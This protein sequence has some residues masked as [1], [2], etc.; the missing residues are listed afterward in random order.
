MK[1]QGL[2][3]IIPNYNGS[4][5][6]ENNLPSVFAALQHSNLLYEVLVVDDCSTDNS[7]EFIGKNYPN[8]K[9][10]EKAKNTGFSA[11][12]NVG[13][14]QAK[15]P[16]IMLLNSDIQLSLDY[17]TGQLDYF[18]FKDTFGV[19]A[20]IVGA[21]QGE[22]QDTARLYTFNGFKIKANRFFRVENP[23]KPIPTAYLSG[24]NAIVDAEKLRILGGFNEN[25]SPF[26][27]E[28]FDLGLRAWKMGWRCYYHPDTYCLH[29]HSS[30]TRNYRSKNWVKSIFFRNRFIVHAIHLE[31]FQ[32]L[33]YYFQLFTD[34][35]LMWMLGKFYFYKALYQFILRYGEIRASRKNLQNLMNQNGSLRTVKQV[36]KEMKELLAN[37]KISYGLG[38]A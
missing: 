31:K 27:Y 1:Q 22:V 21:K 2:S 5:L 36:Q 14:T 33:M 24:A 25:F 7:I 15:Y 20:K 17:F 30:T 35:L 23:T 12:C 19:M 3:V 18:E 38:K 11:T 9:L 37:Q 32:L 16:Y 13:I 8:I 28:D 34:A 4:L 10:I 6:L 26:Y 29:D